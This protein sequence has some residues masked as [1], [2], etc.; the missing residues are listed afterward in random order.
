MNWISSITH[1]SNKVVRKAAAFSGTVLN[2]YSWPVESI[3]QRLQFSAPITLSTGPIIGTTIGALTDINFQPETITITGMT[4]YN[5]DGIYILNPANQP[6]IRINFGQ[7]IGPVDIYIEGYETSTNYKTLLDQVPASRQARFNRI[8]TGSN[9]AITAFVKNCSPV[10]F[11]PTSDTETAAF[12]MGGATYVY[13]ASDKPFTGFQINLGEDD[14]SRT[15]V[16]TLE[17]WNGS[18]TSM[19]GTVYSTTS[20]DNDTTMIFSQSGIV[21]FTQPSDWAPA[22]V[23]GDPYTTAISNADAAR[24]SNY[25]YS[26]KLYYVRIAPPAP[27]AEVIPVVSIALIE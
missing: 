22:A 1:P 25:T 2:L 18:W 14:Y 4:N 8:L 16:Y 19:G 9:T 24:T 10:A 26:D 27:N 7:R 6:Y 23:S 13:L 12:N 3:L 20:V 15:K 5:H 17:Y 21:K 11:R